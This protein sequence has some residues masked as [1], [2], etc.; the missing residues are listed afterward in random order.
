MSQSTIDGFRIAGVATCVPP[1]VVDNL[2]DD[3]GFDAGEVRKVVQ[4]AGVRERR[5]VDAG[6]DVRRPV[7]RGRR[8]TARAT[9]LGARLDLRASSSS[10]SRRTTGC[11]PR[12]ASSSTGS[13]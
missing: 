7:P 3:L 2:S 4:M 6:R 10:R 1:R 9:R 8:A 12:V 11:R 5:V 13:A